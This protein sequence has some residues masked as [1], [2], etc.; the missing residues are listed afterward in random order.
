MTHEYA[1]TIAGLETIVV[2]AAVGARMLIVLLHGYSMRPTDLSPFAHSLG[3]PATFVLPQ[4]PVR[5]SE[6]AFGWWQID[7]Q[8]R[9]EALRQGARDLADEYPDDIAR[10]R[11]LLAQ[12]VADSRKSFGADKV[13]VGGFSQGGMLACDSL[14]EGTLG[15]VD[16]L[17]LLSSSRIRRREWEARR[18]RLRDLPAFV[19]HGTRDPDLSFA[20]GERL[21]EFLAGA[22]ARVTWAPFD[23]GH[24]IPLVAWRHL[25]KFL[26]PFAAQ[27]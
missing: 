3:V 19:C 16:A 4:A 25:R 7:S 10:P 9:D 14:L 26:A 20:A 22:G 6:N 21:Q 15:E 12:L 23:G 8:A 2:E 27:H 1:R 24:E 18:Q 5:V 13:I 11:E 17:F